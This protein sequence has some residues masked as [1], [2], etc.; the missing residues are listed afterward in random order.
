ME[1]GWTFFNECRQAFTSLRAV[2]DRADA[3]RLLLQMGFKLRAIA[4]Q[5]QLA[6]P[7]QG[8]RGRGGQSLG[9]LAPLWQQLTV[10]DQAGDQAQ[11]LGPCAA[12]SRRLSSRISWARRKPTRRGKC[13]L[14][15]P[16][17][18]KPMPL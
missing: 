12:S 4:V 15:P 17:G 14:R 8:R 18:L 2:A 1:M 7:A 3:A 6:H 9:N 13:Q 11:V 10:V 5:Q 16:S